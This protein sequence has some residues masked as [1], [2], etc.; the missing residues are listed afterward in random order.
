M[1]KIEYDFKNTIIL[2]ADYKKI[3]QN[4][5]SKVCSKI[6]FDDSKITW[7]IF[8][9]DEHEREDFLG[10]IGR[11]C[12]WNLRRYCGW[13]YGHCNPKKNK[14]WISTLSIMKDYDA[15]RLKKDD[16]LADVIIDEITH[17]QTDSDHGSAKYD[18]TFRENMINYYF[19]PIEQAML[20]RKLSNFESLV[21]I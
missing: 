4:K 20:K 13:D 17:I 11:F 3:L 2:Y 6:E 19:S 1:S 8:N 16:F 21:V 14:I 7:V 5:I 18:M 10:Y 9:P 12:G 15:S